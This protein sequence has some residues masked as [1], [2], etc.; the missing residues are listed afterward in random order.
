MLEKDAKSCSRHPSEG[1]VGSELRNC[2]SDEVR[3]WHSIRTNDKIA[4]QEALRLGWHATGRHPTTTYLH[5]LPNHN[6]ITSTPSLEMQATPEN[7]QVRCRGNSTFRSRRRRPPASQPQ[8]RDAAHCQHCDCPL[9][10][11]LIA[12]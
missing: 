8:P 1:R 9:N 3:R 2:P 12:M 11:T 5:L 7:L 10:S 4:L 6:H